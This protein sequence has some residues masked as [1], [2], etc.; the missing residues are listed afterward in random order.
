MSILDRFLVAKKNW[1]AKIGQ[2]TSIEQ[3]T[4]IPT[5]GK[6]EKGLGRYN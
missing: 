3:P 1:A 4:Q 2:P 6:G 5:T